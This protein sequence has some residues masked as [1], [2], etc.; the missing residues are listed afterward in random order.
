MISRDHYIHNNRSA[1]WFYRCFGK[2]WPEM[3]LKFERSTWRRW[4]NGNDYSYV[5]ELKKVD[6]PPRR[7]IEELL[8]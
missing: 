1:M 4:R 5:R 8:N 7:L 2:G 3:N 6:R